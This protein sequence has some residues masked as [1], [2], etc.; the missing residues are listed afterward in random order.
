[1]DKQDDTVLHWLTHAMHAVNAELH[2]WSCEKVRDGY[3]TLDVV[4]NDNGHLMSLYQTAVFCQARAYII[5]SYRTEDTTNTGHDR[6][7]DLDVE[8]DFYHATVRRSVRD[9]QGLPHITCELV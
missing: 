7:D 8:S 4:P 9:M 3:D 1:V 2:A 6:A 5:E